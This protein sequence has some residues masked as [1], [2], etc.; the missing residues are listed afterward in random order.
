MPGPSAVRSGYAK[1]NHFGF[2]ISDFGIGFATAVPFSLDP[3]YFSA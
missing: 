1:A 2:L 3:Y